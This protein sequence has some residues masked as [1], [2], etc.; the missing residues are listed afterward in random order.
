[1]FTEH[2]PERSL[3]SPWMLLQKRVTCRGTLITGKSSQFDFTFFHSLL[4]LF[5]FFLE[6]SLTHLK[7]ANRKVKFTE[8]SYC[9]CGGTEELLGLFQGDAAPAE[10]GIP[11]KGQQVN[12]NDQSGAGTAIEEHSLRV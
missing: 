1:M 8:R 12:E 3:T 11:S 6:K 5:F 10:T 4:H 9:L 2:T 7:V